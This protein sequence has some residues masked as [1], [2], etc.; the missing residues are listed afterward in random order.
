MII[1]ENRKSLLQSL[2]VIALGVGVALLATRVNL[3]PS[4]H[5]VGSLMIGAVVWGAL[6]GWILK[7]RS[8]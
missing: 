4:F 7:T 3:D 2:L 6:M 1:S 8:V 5:K